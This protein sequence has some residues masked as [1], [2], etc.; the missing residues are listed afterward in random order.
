[1]CRFVAYLGSPITLDRLVTEPKHSIITQSFAARLRSEPLNGDGFG[2]AW[3]AP[4]ISPRPAVFRSVQPAWSNRNLSDLARVTRSPVVMGHV[5]AASPGLGVT[6]LNCHPFVRGNLAFM[7]NGEVAEFRRMKRRIQ[8]RLTDESFEAIT[9]TTDSETLF[10]LIMDYW[11]KAEDTP[12]VERLGLALSQAIEEIEALRTELRVK[13]GHYLNLALTDGKHLAVCRYASADCPAP[14]L[15]Y[16]EG[17]TY[18]CVDGVCRMIQP[19]NQLAD[20]IVASEPL[21]T[22]EDWKEVPTGHLLLSGPDHRPRLK[23]LAK[24]GA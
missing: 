17:R 24:S 11:S 1:M 22:V 18:E 16:T 2:L 23:P 9:G 20:L 15:F 19:A 14:S 7:H 21:S 10:A 4:E 3:Y 13:D 12:P 5:R 8:A 6:E